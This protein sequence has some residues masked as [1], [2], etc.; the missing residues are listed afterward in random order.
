M[1]VLDRR[2]FIALPF[3]LA[4][5][6]GGPRTLDLVGRTMGTTYTVKLVDH[7]GRL[8]KADVEVAV[9]AA[10]EVT[11]TTLSNWDAESDVSQFNAAQTT[12]P[13][14]VTRP[15]YD[16][17]RA[18]E[19]IRQASEGRFDVALGPLIET[20]GFGAR[21]A[22]SAAPSEAQI[23]A[24]MAQTGQ[25][26]AMTFGAGTLQKA[27]A[28][29]GLFLSAIGK[30]YGVDRVADA[31]RA[32]GAEDFMVEIGGDLYAQGR[33]EDGQPWRIGIE[34]PD[35]AVAGLQGIAGLKGH[36]MA[37]SGDYRNYFEQGG[38]RYSHI[39]DAQTGR[40]VT[41]Q[42]ASATVVT[43]DAMRADAWATA[44]LVLGSS[45][46]SAIAEANGLAVFFVDR[47]GDRFVTRATSAF[48]AVAA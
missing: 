34:T 33:N 39:L 38:Q 2:S 19:D 37:T 21:G 29:Q 41:H 9:S 11:N 45:K 5:C 48:A 42:T 8:S 28:G 26:G 40:P 13:V 25:G 1:T 16:V 27:H 12:D 30:G 47:E 7:S 6:S 17:A 36:G 23:A 15:L 10:L 3:V 24:A 44:M 46:G 32:L 35:D 20:W 18:A 14:S 4:A 31:L 43:A 22:N